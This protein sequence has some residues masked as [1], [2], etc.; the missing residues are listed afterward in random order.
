MSAGVIVHVP[1]ASTLIPASET[2]SMKL[3]ENALRAELLTVTDRY[4]DELFN[5]R[6]P[7]IRRLVFPVS[8]L[9]VDPERFC[10]D[11]AEPMARLG[12]GVIYT[13]TSD[14]Q[15]LRDPVDGPERDR[16]LSTYY[17]PHHRTL[18][19]MV[20]EAL[21]CHDR[22]L[23]I[24]AHSFPSR[25]LSC[26]LDQS[27]L[28]PDI[29]LGTDDYH[30]PKVLLETAYRVMQDQQWSVAVNRPYAGSLVPMNFYRTDRRV[31]SIMIEVN[32]SLYMDEQTGAKLP[33]FDEIRGCLRTC[34]WEIIGSA[35]T[36]Y[37]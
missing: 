28:R 36:G 12:M 27:H 31:S 8:R 11:E 2:A 18:T 25:P 20:R 7:A 21:S 35:W 5:L 15:V 17:D 23:I 19:G 4:T 9:V 37:G 13:R 32:R 6:S 22:C 24:D 14:G 3:G 33:R 26:D 29:C 30:T 16:L 10:D 1:H 34:L